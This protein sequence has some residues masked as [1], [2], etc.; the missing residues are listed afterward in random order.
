MVCEINEVSEVT[1]K[2]P[3]F[4]DALSSGEGKGIS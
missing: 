3:L 4:W 2:I 1:T